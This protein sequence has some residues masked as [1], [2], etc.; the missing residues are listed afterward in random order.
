MTD[1]NRKNVNF[2]ANG[3]AGTSFMNFVAGYAVRQGTGSDGLRQKA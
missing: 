3:D 2:K 1:A